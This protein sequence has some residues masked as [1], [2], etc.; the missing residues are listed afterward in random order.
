MNLQTERLRLVPITQKDLEVFHNTNTNPFVKRFLWDNKEIPES[1]SSDILNEINTK[2]KEENWGIWKILN[3]ENEDYLG[4]VGFWFFFDEKLPQLLYAL[5]PEHTGNG[6]A[7]EASNEIISYAF[8]KLN[9]EYLVAAMDKPN[10]DSVK[11]CERLNMKLIEE[12]EIEGKP[13][14][15]FKLENK[16][17]TEHG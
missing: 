15:F 13:T 1:V 8:K 2:F 16:N 10:Q 11:V 7:S 12:R 9:F 4:Y 5:L 6:Y 17:Y 14:L 3:A